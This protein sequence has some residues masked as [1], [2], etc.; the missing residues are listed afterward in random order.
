MKGRE[1]KDLKQ[2]REIMSRSFTRKIEGQPNKVALRVKTR[3]A[4]VW[5]ALGPD[6]EEVRAVC[7]IQRE[8]KHEVTV[9]GVE[10]NKE[11]TEGKK[12]PQL[13]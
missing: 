6:W 12:S 8:V 1:T 7:G 13:W 2:R 5:S 10:G 4:E 11:G 3:T 9:T